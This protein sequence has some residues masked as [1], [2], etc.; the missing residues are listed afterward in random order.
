MIYTVDPN[1]E[2]PIMLIDKHI[3]YN[4]EDGQGIDG[5]LFQRELLQLDSMGK[6]SIQVWINSPG[7]SVFEGFAIFNAILNTNTPV[8]TYNIGMAAS[9]AGV[10]FMAGRKRMMADYAMFMT[11]MPGNSSSDKLLAAMAD[12]MVT[13]TSAKSNVSEEDMR[14][15]MKKETWLNA[16][17]CF[18]MGLCTEAPVQTSLANKKWMPAATTDSRVLWIEAKKVAANVL[19]NNTSQTQN[20]TNMS[21]TK[22]TMKL[23]L[24]EAA[25]EDNIVEAIKVIEGRAYTA[26]TRII[27]LETQHATKLTEVTSQATADVKTA[28]DKVT[29]ITGKLTVS[30]ARATTAETALAAKVVEY[31][32][33]K[34]KYDAMELEKT[35]AVEAAKKT[36]ATAMVDAHVRTGRIKNETAVIAK[37]VV[38]AT[39]DLEGT[40]AMIES[41]PLSVTAPVF[42]TEIPA[43]GNRAEGLATNAMHLAVRN[44]LKREGKVVV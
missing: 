1:A 37:W 31:D 40:K 33:I 3:G 21:M 4:D 2:V 20:S 23:G 42:Q 41:I 25:T 29:D 27:Q 12:A 5:S 6:K 39:A 10:I 7:G 43:G 36:A 18:E 19:N 32:A 9:M 11:H 17:D 30:E 14:K 35:N 28:N 8:D 24:V 44:K 13:M 16:T 26:E 34:A 38:L 22:V 15:M